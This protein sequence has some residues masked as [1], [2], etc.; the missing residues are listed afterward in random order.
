MSSTTS[1]LDPYTANAENNDVTP[2]EKING[3]LPLC[4]PKAILTFDHNRTPRN[5]Q[6]SE[7]RNA[8][9][10]IRRRI[11]SFS[12]HD[13]RVTYVTTTSPATKQ[14]LSIYSHFWPV[15][16]T[17]PPPPAYSN[18]QL[19]LVF[20][21]NNASHK[22]EEIEHDGNVNVSFFNGDTTAWAS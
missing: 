18:T 15:Q 7:S 20:L 17:Y 1:R 11:I 14:Y 4:F 19:T 5:R 2:Q 21:A 13:S 9:H 6:R 16:S 12:R 8:Y 10:T 3:L 22:F